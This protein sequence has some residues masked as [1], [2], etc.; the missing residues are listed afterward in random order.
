M[1]C[2]QA[3]GVGKGQP[4]LARHGGAIPLPLWMLA[5]FSPS[6]TKQPLEENFDFQSEKTGCQG[7]QPSDKILCVAQLRVHQGPLQ[8]PQLYWAKGNQE[9]DGPCCCILLCSDTDTEIKELLLI[10]ACLTS[11]FLGSASLVSTGRRSQSAVRWEHRE[12]DW[13]SPLTRLSRAAEG[14]AGMSPPAL[15][16]PSVPALPSMTWLGFMRKTT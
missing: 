5:A 15:I 14:L 1:S 11:L 6:A 13:V 4:P 9:R 12:R 7:S 16:H 10:P 3:G 2:Q 8:H